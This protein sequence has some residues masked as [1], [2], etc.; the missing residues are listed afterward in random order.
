VTILGSLRQGLLEAARRWRVVLTLYLIN[1]IAA[2]ALSAPMAA[3]L[4]RTIGRS[5]AASGIEANFR[6][7]VILDFVRTERSALADHFQTIAVGVLL[8]A[9]VAALLTGD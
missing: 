8:Y 3:L 7:D 9:A 4:D 5:V 2:A 1:L 6:F